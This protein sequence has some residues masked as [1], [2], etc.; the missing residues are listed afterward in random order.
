VS[1]G[2]AVL[3]QTTGAVT[4]G[5]TGTAAFESASVVKLFTIVES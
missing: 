5:A 4:T 2:I 1:A 3:D